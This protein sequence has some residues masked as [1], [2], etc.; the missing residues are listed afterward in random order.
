MAV[1]VRKPS[2][3]LD[4]ARQ[5]LAEYDAQ[6]YGVQTE[7]NI[8]AVRMMERLHNSYRTTKDVI[9]TI[10]FVLERLKRKSDDEEA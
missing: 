5:M 7:P 3:D 6:K 4:A 9:Q 10:A 2:D 8:E 1:E